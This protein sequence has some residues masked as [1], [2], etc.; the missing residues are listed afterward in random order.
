MGFITRAYILK[1]N[2]LVQY[3]GGQPEGSK[4]NLQVLILHLGL[5]SFILARFNRRW[6]QL[7]TPF[8]EATRFIMRY[9]RY[10]RFFASSLL[11]VAWGIAPL[12]MLWKGACMISGSAYPI[13]VVSSESMEPAFRRGDLILLWNQQEHIRAGDIP[14]VWF[15]GRP[16]PMVHRAIKVSYQ[17]TN[18]SEPAAYTD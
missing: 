6:V 1:L 15:P 2:A 13:M 4:A 7:W 12:F 8:K 3:V 5:H 18:Q 9:S 16:L 14:V 10:F 17:I 11:P